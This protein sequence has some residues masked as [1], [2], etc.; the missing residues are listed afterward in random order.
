[1]RLD[2][3]VLGAVTNGMVEVAAGEIASLR[4]RR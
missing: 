2:E 3:T 1:V 4:L